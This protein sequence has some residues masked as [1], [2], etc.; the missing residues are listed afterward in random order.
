MKLTFINDCCSIFHRQVVQIIFV[1]LLFGGGA[2]SAQSCFVDGPRYNLIGDT[3]S[4]SLTIPN[5]G[6]SCIRGIR[7]NNVEIRSV[8]LSTPPRSGRVALK[9]PSFTYTPN[10][11][12]SDEDSFTLT[13][14]GTIN[15]KRGSST[16]HVSVSITGLPRE[17]ATP[18][19]VNRPPTPTAIPQAR[20]KAAI[21]NDVHLLV[22]KTLPP[23]PIWDW[24]DRS[25]PP[26]RPPFDRSKLFCPPPPFKPPNPP[27]GCICAD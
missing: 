20:Q 5:G 18:G 6:R 26:M 7:F 22:G 19:S 25:P 4:W 21:D 8:M 2:A 27:I 1:F 15:K 3:V 17:L 16:I 23:C 10:K 9:G 14:D 13:I 24:S 11:N 12:F